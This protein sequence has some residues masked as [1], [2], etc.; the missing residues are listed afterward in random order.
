M[1][2]IEAYPTL[3][4]IT[5]TERA[6]DDA[7]DDVE[8][9][10]GAA[11]AARLAGHVAPPLRQTGLP[12]CPRVARLHAATAS[13]APYARRDDLE[14]EARTDL[15]DALNQ[16]SELWDAGPYATGC[17][18][19]LVDAA[20]HTRRRLASY[21]QLAA[22]CRARA[23]HAVL[24]HGE[25]K[26][27]NFLDTAAG[28][29]LVDW[30]T[31][32]LAPGARDLW[33]LAAEGPRR[34]GSLRGEHR[35]HGAPRRYRAVPAALGSHRHRALRLPTARPSRPECRRGSCLASFAATP[36]AHA[37]DVGCGPAQ[38]QWWTRRSWPEG[39]R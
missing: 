1:I 7:T 16:L 38:Q 14:I 8:G 36:Q 21:D 28:P 23:A 2:A 5:Q 4:V 18:D 20:D 34:C 11:D 31:A 35:A 10:P 22:A 37:R 6:W 39:D 30:D 27:D 26:P 13:A 12:L 24:S 32:L 19:L 29:A 9:D 3:L 33:W 25:P 15:E 17:R